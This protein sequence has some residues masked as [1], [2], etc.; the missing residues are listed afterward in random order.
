MES[1]GSQAKP[2]VNLTFAE[3]QKGI[4]EPGVV[5]S[6]P[7][8]SASHSLD[9]THS[10][11]NNKAS[12]LIFCFVKWTQRCWSN[13]YSIAYCKSQQM[14]KCD[15]WSLTDVSMCLTLFLLK[16]CFNGRL[17]R[18]ENNYHGDVSGGQHVLHNPLT[19]IQFPV[20]PT[21]HFHLSEY[22]L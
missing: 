19:F 20:E 9:H 11:H 15:V 2:H 14:S 3:A 22:L 4:W 7:L 16:N 6:Y 5:S 1:R 21:L 12:R 13:V 17:K 10:Y 18:F 8:K